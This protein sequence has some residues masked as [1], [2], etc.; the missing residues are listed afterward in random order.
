MGLGGRTVLFY[1][2]ELANESVCGA[3]HNQ[4]NELPEDLVLCTT[5]GLEHAGRNVGGRMWLKWRGKLP[6][7]IYVFQAVI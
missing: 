4:H 5:G 7:V 3:P 1:A 2:Q 6:T